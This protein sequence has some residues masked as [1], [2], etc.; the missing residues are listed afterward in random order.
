ML[1]EGL[2]VHVH[3]ALCKVEFIRQRKTHRKAR[4]RK[5]YRK[6]FG[7][8]YECRAKE[9][10]QI[11]R[12][13][14]V[15]PHIFEALKKECEQ[16]ETMREQVY[17]GASQGQFFRGLLDSPFGQRGGY[18]VPTVRPQAFVTSCV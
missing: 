3:P 9:A 1:F 12:N 6:K 14:Y 2:S 16:R 10:K 8:I 7:C 11:G 5:K 4:I 18:Q 13:L 15:C 17:V